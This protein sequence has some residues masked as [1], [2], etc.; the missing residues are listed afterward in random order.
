MNEKNTTVVLGESRETSDSSIKGLLEQRNIKVWECADG[1]EAIRKSFAKNPDLIILDVTLPRLNGYQFARILKSDPS[2]NSTPIIHMGSSRNPI[3]RY[4]SG[5]CGGD[6]YLEKPVN[7]VDLEKALNTFLRKESGKRQLLAPVSTIPDLDDQSI[8]ALATKLLEQ[9]LLRANILNEINMID[10]SAMT[11]EDLVMAV[12]AIVGSLYDFAVA[13]ALFLYIDHG[14]IFFYQNGQVEQDRLDEVKKLILKHLQRQYEIYLDP[15]QIKQNLLQSNQVKEVSR[16]TDEVYIHTKES[17]PVRSVLAFQDIGF[18][19]LKENDRE[20][21]TLALDLAQGVLEK[22]IFFQM[23]QELSIIDAATEGDSMAFFMT[24]LRREIE[25]AIR[26]RYPITLMTIA[27]SNYKQITKDLSTD[28]VHG[29]IRIIQNLILKV[30][31]KSDIV[32]RWEMASFAFLLTHTSLE[33]ARVSQERISKY[34]MNNIS[35][36]LPSSAELVMD[37]G[38]SQFNPER[39]KTPEIF[40]ANAKPKEKSLDEAN[41]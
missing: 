33:K 26:N 20:I 5:V 21:L 37:M 22:K 24:I 6:D 3:E 11:A 15:K 30:M 2:M 36:H 27:I 10:I 23:S 17:G 40:F 32:A 18:K 29:L 14:E 13:T 39:D 38:I 41:R 34:I 12:M 31:R 16:E 7:E 19:E 4:W 28:E 25:N 35:Q 9:E 8:L 1:I